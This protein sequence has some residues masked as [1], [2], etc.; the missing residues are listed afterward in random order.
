MTHR[1]IPTEHELS[2]VSIV[3]GSNLTVKKYFM[4]DP[5]C[6]EIENLIYRCRSATNQI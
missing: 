3:H 2:S 6:A 1:R 4:N 5:P